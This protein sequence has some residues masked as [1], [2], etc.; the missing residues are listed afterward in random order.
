MLEIDQSTDITVLN[1]SPQLTIT[2]QRISLSQCCHRL[3]CKT[4]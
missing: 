2:A 1:N 3:L 4:H